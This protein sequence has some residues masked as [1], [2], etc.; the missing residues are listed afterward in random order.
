MI[1]ADIETLGFTTAQRRVVDACR[2]LGGS[3]ADFTV[4]QLMEE[5]QER[6][7]ALSRSYA[8]QTVRDVANRL[9]IAGLPWPR[10][11]SRLGVNST[12][13]YRM[14]AVENATEAAA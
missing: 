12:A 4:E 6:G 13:V 14:Q 11:V 10:R 7:G 9:R 3:D 1:R 8:M 2:A 5:I